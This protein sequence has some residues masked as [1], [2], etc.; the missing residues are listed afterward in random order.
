MTIVFEDENGTSLSIHYEDN[1]MYITVGGENEVDRRD[2]TM[3]IEDVEKFIAALK[4]VTFKS[5]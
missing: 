4:F 5:I 2:N 3:H 1:E